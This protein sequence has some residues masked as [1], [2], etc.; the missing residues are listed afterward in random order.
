MDAFEGATDIT[1]MFMILLKGQ[2]MDSGDTEI[3]NNNLLY[4]VI[5]D[6]KNIDLT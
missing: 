6:N 4:L 5:R 2:V 3:S 1:K